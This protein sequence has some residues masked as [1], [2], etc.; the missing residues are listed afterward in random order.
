MTPVDPTAPAPSPR[1]A[2]LVVAASIAGLEGAV[3]LLLAVLEA[4]SIDSDRVSLGVSTAIFFALGY[5]SQYELP[6]GGHMLNLPLATLVFVN[7]KLGGVLAMFGAVALLFVL[8][9][10]DTHP[11]RSAMFRPIFRAA[12]LVLV[13]DFVILGWIGSQVPTNMLTIMGQIGTAYYLGF[14]L[15]ILPVLSHTE[16]ALPLPASINESV[17]RHSQ[18]K[19][20]LSSETNR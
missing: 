13:V 12:L 9:W 17:L 1:P 8:P 7:A 11:V 16:K 14:F 19:A 2:P 3:L 6:S 5:A 4:A 10:L 18:A 20:M 15:V